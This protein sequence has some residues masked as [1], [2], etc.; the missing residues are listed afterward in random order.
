MTDAEKLKIYDIL[1]VFR[2]KL[3]D[4]H[5]DAGT[6]EDVA[7][8]ALDSVLYLAEGVFGKMSD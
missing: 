4:L 1:R 3:W 2:R 5:A 8:N 6:S 7:L